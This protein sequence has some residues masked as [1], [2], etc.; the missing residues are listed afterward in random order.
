MTVSTP[1]QT[2]YQRYAIYYA[3]DAN[4][5]LGQFGNSWLGRDPETG[6]TLPRPNDTAL[7]GDQIAKI[8]LAPTKYGFH[9]TLKAP[10]ALKPGYTV[11]DL[12]H[13]LLDLTSRHTPVSCGPLTIKPIGHFLALVPSIP[14]QDLNALAE[15]CVRDL[16]DLRA[17]LSPADL[18]RRRKSKL[19]AR[20]DSLLLDWGYP[21]VMEEFRFHMTLTDKIEQPELDT[22]HTTLE[23]LFKHRCSDDTLVVDQ[24]CLFG[25]PGSG[26]PFKLLKRYPL[27]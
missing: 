12:D 23:H 15:A 26:Y 21:Y 20:Q 11:T 5:E 1:H 10:F 25:D 7:S 19:T 14:S 2:P 22:A 8:T 24:V 4:S 27:R 17:A 6:I 18:E 9:G 3:P 13:A 16:D